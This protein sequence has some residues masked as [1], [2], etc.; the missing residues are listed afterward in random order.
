MPPLIAYEQALRI[1]SRD[2]AKI[3]LL[4]LVEEDMLERGCD[5]ASSL[6]RIKATLAWRA[7]H[8][9]NETRERVER[10]YRCAHPVFGSYLEMG[11]PSAVLAILMLR[12]AKRFART[13]AAGFAERAVKG[14]QV[15]VLN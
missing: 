8:K 11:P 12:H 7:Y 1:H 3:H 9:G 10:L 5:A 14:N 4:L 13:P 2:S 6:R 15:C